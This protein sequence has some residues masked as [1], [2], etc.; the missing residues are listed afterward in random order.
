MK[1]LIVCLLAVLLLTGCG[2][3]PAPES[4]PVQPEQVQKPTAPEP[5]PV[6]PE[7]PAEPE[8][9]PE[10]EEPESGYDPSRPMTGVYVDTSRLE[11]FEAPKEI[12]SRRTEGFADELV[13][14]D[15]GLLRP[16]YGSRAAFDVTIY[17]GQDIFNGAMGLIDEN[18]AIV[19]DP[20]Y[21][22][23]SLLYDRET[24]GAAPFYLLAKEHW[25]D[26]PGGGWMGCLYGLC[27]VDG[28]L[29]LPC[30]YEQFSCYGDWI[31]G[32]RD[33][34]AGIFHVFDRSGNR[35]LNSADWANRPRINL[36]G[37][38]IGV[39]VSEHLVVISTLG[40]AG[41]GG[42][43]TG[44]SLYNWAGELISDQYEW[45]DLSGE[46]PYACGNWKTDVNGYLNENGEP[47]LLQYTGQVGR[48]RNGKA[49]AELD[50]VLQVI[51][52]EGNVLW[53]PPEETVYTFWTAEGDYY[54]CQT[55]SNRANT[56]YFDPDFRE[57]FPEADQIV[58][59]QGL[60]YLVWQDGICR[61]TDGVRSLVLEGAEDQ[62]QNYYSVGYGGGERDL[63]VI[64]R[65]IQ[66]QRQYW[67]VN[68]ELELLAC[69]EQEN[70][71]VDLMTD[72]LGDGTMA[73]WYDMSGMYY[74]YDFFAL[75][76]PGAPELEGVRVLGVYGGWYL[77]E[78]EFSS[79]YM[80]R[81]GNWLFRV[82]LMT[83]MVD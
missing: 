55:G 64:Q 59:L 34:E 23:V 5:V 50:G 35:L 19:V 4:V 82:N 36:S 30:D 24:M 49:L 8:E 9:S 80:D 2:A 71:G 48:F 33:S 51:D 58:H 41:G 54:S 12:V 79:G 52:P 63:I 22:S 46:P 57:L 44:C 42:W 15:Y 78:D 1:R 76:Y 7:T 18:G 26:Y 47:T 74:P 56:R 28:S 77:V 32:V 70:L 40:A 29:V 37:G 39:E 14:G 81:N 61:L 11:N 3:V 21:A 17:G 27:S 45:V 43:D 66:Q 69:V 68:R 20:V 6:V 31:V 67:L 60:Y 53:T 62:R 73:V 10:P 83:D 16:Y 25:V 72:W 75:D 38:M 65:S 13:S